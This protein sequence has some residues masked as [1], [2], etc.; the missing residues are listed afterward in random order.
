MYPEPEIKFDI[1]KIKLTTLD[2]EV[3]SEN[4]FPDVESAA[5]EIL[6]YINTGLYNK[7]DSHMGSR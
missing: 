7:T 5:E 3:K 4:G 1:S 6:T 2:I